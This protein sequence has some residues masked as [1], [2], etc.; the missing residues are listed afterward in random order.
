MNDINYDNLDDT[1]NPSN[2]DLNT[3]SNLDNDSLID[4][5]TDLNS[6]LLNN[7][8]NDSN[9]VIKSDNPSE[10]DNSISLNENNLPSVDNNNT[11]EEL[12][13]DE[14]VNIG[15]T[16]INADKPKKKHTLLI[17][18][19]V[20]L[21]ILG[22]TLFVGLKLIDNTDDIKDHFDDIGYY[23]QQIVD[24]VSDSKVDINDDKSLQEAAI[25][26]LFNKMNVDDDNGIATINVSKGV[27]YAYYDLDALNNLDVIKNNDIVINEIGFD[28]ED[29]QYINIY[30]SITYKEKIKAGLQ[31]QL[32]YEFVDDE[33]IIKFIDAKIGKLPTFIYSSK[34]PK[35]GNVL[36]KKD[37]SY[38]YKVNDDISVKIFSPSDIKD[39]TYDK[40]TGVISIEF[41]YGNALNSIL[42]DLFN[43]D[44]NGNSKFLD[45]LEYYISGSANKVSGMLDSAEDYIEE[46]YGVNFEDISSLI[47]TFADLFN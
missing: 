15:V 33:I 40:Q 47:D 20:I 19:I 45:I 22:I 12:H 43:T 31:G 5:K 17:I 37:I 28:L 44:D 16:N 41:N 8:I 25:N 11:C 14:K 7:D 38:S 39:I 29:N 30:A 10:N 24:N 35:S 32:S 23:K 18:L 21:A 13:K 27:I 26:D 9:S 6:D 2:E 34:L 3:S 36:F 4:N 46:N 1:N 42:E